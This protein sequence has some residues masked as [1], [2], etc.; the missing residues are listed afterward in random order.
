MCVGWVLG[1]VVGCREGEMTDR[2]QGMLVEM[3]GLFLA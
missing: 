2:G 1:E 3:G